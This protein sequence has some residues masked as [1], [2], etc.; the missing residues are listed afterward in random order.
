M[1]ISHK[2]IPDLDR[3]AAKLTGDVRGAKRAGMINI[4]TSVEARAVKAAPVKKSNLANSGSNEVNQDG[5]QGIVTFSA[6][7]AGYVHEGTGL[8]GPHETK[9]VPKAKKALYWPGAPHPIR[10]VKGMKANPFLLKA[11]QESDMEKLFTE[12][13]ENYLNRQ[14]AA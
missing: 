13:A 7:Y 1:N 5:S 2:F 14:G 8:Y 6:P 9:I 4:V 10:A 11:A 3:V 12:G